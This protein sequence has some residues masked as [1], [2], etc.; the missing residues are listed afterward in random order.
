MGYTEYLSRE[1]GVW[2]A[3]A[4]AMCRQA[5]V[6]VVVFNYLKPGNIERALRG[7]DVGTRIGD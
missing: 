7:E 3:T 6:P 5:R 4:I 1:L 2:D